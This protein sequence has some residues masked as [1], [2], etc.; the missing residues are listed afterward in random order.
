MGNVA[1][2]TQCFSNLLGNAVKFVKPG[3]LPQVVIEAEQ[4][5]GWVRLWFIDRGIGI[6]K[7]MLARVFDMF[8]R[9]HPTYEGTGIGLGLVQKVMKR[10]GGNVGV[11]SE[12][13]QGS[14]FWLE[15]KPADVA[16]ST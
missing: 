6:P 9:G 12:E 7:A 1:G 5:G 2:L 10:M 13:G 16:A 4:L 3:E 14:R 15:L 8:S 11:E